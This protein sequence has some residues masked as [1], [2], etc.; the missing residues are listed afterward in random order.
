[1][2]RIE[3]DLNGTSKETVTLTDGYSINEHVRRT[4]EWRVGGHNEPPRSMCV[5]RWW[6]SI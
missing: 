5:V 6:Q 1:L 2:H 3:S 4:T